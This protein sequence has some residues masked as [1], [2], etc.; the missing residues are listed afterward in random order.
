MLQTLFFSLLFLQDDLMGSCILRNFSL[1]V[2]GKSLD[3][4]SW[5][6]KFLVRIQQSA[7]MGDIHVVSILL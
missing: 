3:T 4:L 7:E 5:A 1:S 6:F 2:L